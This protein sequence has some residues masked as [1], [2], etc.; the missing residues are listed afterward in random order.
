MSG[1]CI[2]GRANS[3]NVQK[4]LWCCGELDLA[5]ERVDAGMAH[6]VVDSAEYRAMNPNGRVPTLVDGDFVLWESNAIIRYLTLKQIEAGSEAAI[7]LYPAAAAKRAPVERWLDWILTTM[8]PAERNLFWSMVRTKPEDRDPKLI[9][10]ATKASAE[11]WAVLEAH[12]AHGGTFVE[13]ETFH[14]WPISCWAPMRAAGLVSR[15]PTGRPMTGSGPGMTASPSARCSS[16]TLRRRCHSQLYA[17]SI[18]STSTRLR[19]ERLAR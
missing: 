3:V 1:L 16:A 6:G 11:C 18:N 17:C 13:G 9:A 4:V 14:P 7:S 2:W 5:F 12:L 15:S 10:T 8:Q 19:P